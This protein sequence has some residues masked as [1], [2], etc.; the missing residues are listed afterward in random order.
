VKEIRKITVV[1]T[2]NGAHGAAAD[3]TLR[4]YQVTLYELPEFKEN[5]EA[6]AAKGGIRIIRGEKEQ[7]VKIHKFTTNAA[8]AF[9]GADCIM[10]VV[11]TFAHRTIAET[12]APHSK[13]GQTIILNPGSTGGLLEFMKVFQEK[14]GAAKIDWAETASLPYGARLVGPGVVN[15]LLDTKAVFFAAF[16]ATKTDEMLPQFKK[17]FPAA[18]KFKNILDTALN[19]G[20]PVSHPTAAI[21]NTGRI[22]FTKGNYLHYKEGITPSVARVMEDVDK[23][24]MAIIRAYGLTEMSTAERLVVLGYT[25]S[26]KDLYDQY[27]HSEVFAP[28]K[29]PADLH[30]RFI[31]EDIAYGLVTWADLGDLAGVETPLMDAVVHIASSIHGVNYF[32]TGRTLKNLGLGH[33]TKN[34]LLKYVT[35]GRL[36][37]AR[38]GKPIP[39]KRRKS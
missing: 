28:M 38:S 10:P 11:P 7:I 19:N 33:L 12:C 31:T 36:R 20:N 8:E 23:E 5:L 1:G 24:R 15:I 30:N 35:S 32:N 21:L 16:P 17:M 6:M 22:E 4:G 2:G 9:S 14:G 37:T 3:L 18:L 13:D 25:H 29:A 26:G 39:T 27:Q 34:H